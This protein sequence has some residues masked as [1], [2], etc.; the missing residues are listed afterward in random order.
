MNHQPELLLASLQA[1]EVRAAET[2]LRDAMLYY[3][4]DGSE[5][6]PE[7]HLQ[8]AQVLQWL[9]FEQYS[10]EPYIA[11]MKFWRTWGGIHNKRPDEIALWQDRG[12][13]A[14]QVM[15]RHL[16]TR[17][18]FV[19]ERYTIA[20]IALYAY[21]H[22]AGLVGFDLDAVPAVRAWLERVASQPGHVRIANGP[23]SLL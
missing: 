15:D 8:R 6:W 22:T 17:R 16:R 14:L 7:Q 5:F 11:V 20:D 4:A 21:T 9:F 12:Q 3:L 23:G 10:H 2:T 1:R 18:F 13:Q 19:A